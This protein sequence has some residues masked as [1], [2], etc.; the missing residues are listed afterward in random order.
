MMK[1]FDDS[2]K[3]KLTPMQKQWLE[4]KKQYPEHIIFWRLG[5]FYETFKEDAI[6]TSKALNI[7]LTSR[8]TAETEW[9]LAGVPYHA[10]DSYLAR[11]VE[12][13]YKVA[14]VEQL[15]DPSKAKTIVKRGVV[16]LVSKGTVLA[17]ESLKKSNNFLIA[18]S[19]ENDKYGLAALDLSTGDFYVTDFSDEASLDVEFTRLSPAE[20]VIEKELWETLNLQY[21]T[22]RCVLTFK[23][24]Y[25][26]DVEQGKHDL[27]KFFQ[28]ATLDGFG[29][30]EDGVYIAAAGAI[31]NYLRET[32]F[33]ETF[34]NITKI[35]KI[36][37]D[38]F[39]ILDST[40]IMSLELISNVRDRTEFGTLRYI[41]DNTKTGPGSRLLTRWLLHPS[42]NKEIIEK[43]LNAVDEL[44]QD[45]ITREDIREILGDMSDI[46]RIISRVALGRARPR[47]LLALKE[48]L[49]LIPKI[50]KF[51]S[52]YQSSYFI[53]IREKLNPLKE[54]VNIIERTI[55]ENTSATVGDG[56]VIKE[57]YNKELDELKNIRKNSKKFLQSLEAREKQRTG[58]KTLK[59][60][61]NKV[62]GY[63]I[64]VSKVY[65]DQ[66]PAEYERKQT[67]TNAERY[68]TPE[69]KEYEIKIL[70][71]EEKIIAI[72]ERL[73]NEILNEISKFTNQIKETAY[74]CAVLDVLS[75]FAQNAINFN[76]TKPEIIE[77]N[78]YYI[79][80]G[81]HPVVEQ[82]LKDSTFIPNDCVIEEKKNRLLIITGPNMSGKSTFL[83][84]TAL[85]VL[86]A[87]IGSFVPASKAR[88]GL[89]DRIFT[90]IGAHDV[91]I[92]NRSTFMV[93]M[94][95]SANILNNATERS[96]VILD[97]IGRGTSTFDGVALA[98]AIA[99]YLHNN[100]GRIGPRTLLAT[101]YHEL[102]ELEN[103]LP[104]VKNYHVAVKNVNGSVHFLY[105]V[106]EGGIDESYGVHVASLAGIPQRVIER[107]N[108]VLH[109]LHAQMNNREQRDEKQEEK[110]KKGKLTPVQVTLLGETA[111]QSAIENKRTFTKKSG[112]LQEREYKLL[113]DIA[114][115]NVNKIT[116]IEAINLLDQL[117]RKCRNILRKKE[118]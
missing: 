81:R 37:T 80:E 102:I 67:L 35:S 68:I 57:G 26:F 76:Y 89:T 78:S 86:L 24:S 43:R 2:H 17:P 111:F 105:K 31:I 44:F 55:S 34:P 52:K 15:E 11:M 104:R 70:S 48:T 118:E 13:G 4:V 46:E 49:Q 5:D 33:R 98:W 47:E 12:Q 9:P 114:N 110:V 32:Q 27:L 8:K 100:I 60:K 50:K 54:V 40:T 117:T 58:I 106:K 25:Y 103:I 79:T 30:E 97:E 10:V 53:E 65:S 108:E 72:E 39:M 16:R 73:Y 45:I 107:A 18:I 85:I 20:I 38:E 41:L 56:T 88:I 42:L 116:P 84:Q 62:F 7:T 28:L 36:K 101:H 23:P 77:E 64:E 75:T 71:A 21:N 22:K 82:L 95:E 94:I 3:K 113:Q 19:K 59:V 93:E 99:E 91:L 74:F 92:E 29:L 112:I 69:L 83:R 66:V 51:L 61:F 6:T 109:V 90:R 115:I 14:I 1:R 96:L 63:F 87:H